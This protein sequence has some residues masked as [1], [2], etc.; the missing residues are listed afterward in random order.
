LETARLK[1]VEGGAE[2][3]R[4]LLVLPSNFEIK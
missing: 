2:P 4:R 3:S 1:V